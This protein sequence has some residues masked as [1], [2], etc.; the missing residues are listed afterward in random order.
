MIDFEQ[1]SS[2]NARMESPPTAGLSARIFFA[3]AESAGEAAAKPKRKPGRP[4]GK[5]PEGEP[6]GLT[7]AQKAEAVTLWRSGD[8]TLD[9]LAKKFDKRRELFSRMF[10]RMGIEKGSGI[11]AA[12]AKAVEAA[13]TRAVRD[14]EET[15][16]KIAKVKDQH[17]RMSSDI[18]KLA[19]AEI[20]RARQ[21]GL[22][23]G[24][25]KDVMATLKAA[26]EIVANARKEA[27]VVLDVEKHEAETELE[28]LPELTVRELT[29]SEIEQ[30]QQATGD[31]GLDDDM[32]LGDDLDMPEGA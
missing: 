7:V 1:P 9:M 3:M 12:T 23:L 30:L 29:T 22:D 11:A 24:T 31:D 26:G 14:T 15:L 19:Y 27:Y 5:K 2:D 4:A 6:R 28:D 10:K 8:Y 18:A 20:L 32:G 25:L 17:L 13:E 16:Q 21:A